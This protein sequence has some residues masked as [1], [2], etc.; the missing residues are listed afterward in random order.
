MINRVQQLNYSVWFA[1][2]FCEKLQTMETFEEDKKFIRD[3]DQCTHYAICKLLT[4]MAVNLVVKKAMKPRIL[5]IFFLI[6]KT[7]LDDQNA[8]KNVIPL[9]ADTIAANLEAINRIVSC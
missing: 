8:R 7:R 9:G 5:L 3:D 1:F 4:Q 6:C 2:E